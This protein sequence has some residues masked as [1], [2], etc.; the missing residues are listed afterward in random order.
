MSILGIQSMLDEYCWLSTLH[1]TIQSALPQLLA[2]LRSVVVVDV[3]AT[4]FG[5]EAQILNFFLVFACSYSMDCALCWG[6]LCSF[7]YLSR[8]GGT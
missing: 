8:G 6:A 5:F 7:Q 1:T 2:S 4:Y 3:A